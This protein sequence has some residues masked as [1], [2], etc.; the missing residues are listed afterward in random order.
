MKNLPFLALTLAILFFQPARSMDFEVRDG[1]VV[2]RSSSYRPF[3][4]LKNEGACLQ[5]NTN[6]NCVFI[7]LLRVLNTLFSN[8]YIKNNVKNLRISHPEGKGPGLSIA[9]EGW[10]KVF[11][12]FFPN[13]KRENVEYYDENGVLRPL[14]EAEHRVELQ[15]Q[16][17]DSCFL[18]R[19]KAKAKPVKKRFTSLQSFERL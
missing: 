14:T 16:F 1:I 2:Y 11:T 17:A 3:M 13:L 8:Q 15:K 5:V 6:S 4:E 9:G 18:N 10:I 12:D 19:L 7:K